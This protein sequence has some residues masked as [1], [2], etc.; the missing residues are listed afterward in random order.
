MKNSEVRI[1]HEYIAKVSG[2]AAKVRIDEEH[3]NGGWNA[4]NLDTNR[5]V[6]IRSARRLSTAFFQKANSKVRAEG[7][8]KVVGSI[9]EDSHKPEAK[10]IEEVVKPVEATTPKLK[11]MSGLDAAVLILGQ[12]CEP[13]NTRDIV[14]I[15]KGK[16]YWNPGGKTPHATLYSAIIREIATKGDESR[17]RKAERGK[18]ELVTKSERA[19]SAGDR[20]HLKSPHFEGECDGVVAEFKYDEGWMYRLNVDGEAPKEATERSGEVWVLENEITLI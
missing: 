19:F 7:D 1:G 17:F 18:F 8:Q 5:Q 4:T 2:K 6:R 13:M 9:V 16:G 3:H 15:A 14:D 10:R 20:V 11:N 12:Q